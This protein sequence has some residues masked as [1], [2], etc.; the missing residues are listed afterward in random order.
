MTK[1]DNERMIIGGDFNAKMKSMNKNINKS[2]LESRLQTHC[3]TP[4]SLKPVIELNYKCDIALEKRKTGN[5][6]RKN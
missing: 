1:C 6:T 5:S 3:H 4:V 2:K